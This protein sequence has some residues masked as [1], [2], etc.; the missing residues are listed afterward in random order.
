MK[1]QHVNIVGTFFHRRLEGTADGDGRMTIQQ[2]KN[3]GH[4]A[5]QR[6]AALHA[7]SWRG[8]VVGLVVNIPKR[9]A[10]LVPQRI[11]EELGPFLAPG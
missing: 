2:T 1:H 9:E 4:V 10:R 8:G 7:G 5:G 6:N 11:D 3:A